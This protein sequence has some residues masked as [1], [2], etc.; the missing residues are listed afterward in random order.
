M[1]GVS[2]ERTI[3][4]GPNAVTT[5][6][7]NLETS[8]FSDSEAE[9]RKY[10]NDNVVQVCKETEYIHIPDSAH[11]VE[12][13]SDK[14][15]QDKSSASE[16]IITEKSAFGA[17]M[18]N[19]K[20]SALSVQEVFS[21][22]SF[23]MPQI[24]KND[25]L[26]L[27]NVSLGD[28]PAGCV[29]SRTFVN[30]VTEA[31]LKEAMGNI[32]D[33]Y[34][35]LYVHFVLQG[36]LHLLT[37]ASNKAAEILRDYRVRVEPTHRTPVVVVEENAHIEN[38]YGEED[39]DN[40]E[41]EDF[42]VPSFSCSDTVTSSTYPPVQADLS[43]GTQLSA[44]LKDF[45][46]FITP[47]TLSC[48][49]DKTWVDENVTDVLICIVAVMSE[50]QDVVISGK[51]VGTL[52]DVEQGIGLLT[53]IMSSR[54][55]LVETILPRLIIDS[56]RNSSQNVPLPNDIYSANTAIHSCIHGRG[57]H[58]LATFNCEDLYLSIL[59]CVPIAGD[60]QND[61]MAMPSQRKNRK[62]HVQLGTDALAP[63]LVHVNNRV[64][65]DGWRAY[66]DAV[67]IC[68]P[69]IASHAAKAV[70]VLS[71]YKQHQKTLRAHI[72]KQQQNGVSV[73]EDSNV[74]MK[75]IKQAS[76]RKAVLTEDS[77][78]ELR[79]NVA[80]IVSIVSRYVRHGPAQTVA[81][82][83]LKYGVW[84]D[85]VRLFVLV[86]EIRDEDARTSTKVPTQ[87]E[88]HIL[89]DRDLTDLVAL[90]TVGC[91][92]H[93]ELYTYTLRVAEA[94]TL[95]I[96]D[97]S[98]VKCNHPDLYMI[99]L[100]MYGEKRAPQAVYTFVHA[101]HV[102]LLNSLNN[103]SMHVYCEE[104]AVFFKDISALLSM[105]SMFRLYHKGD[106]IKMQTKTIYSNAKSEST[107][108]ST[109]DAEQVRVWESM[110]PVFEDI[111]IYME[112]LLKAV[113]GVE[114]FRSEFGLPTKVAAAPL[115]SDK[116]PVADEKKTEG[117]TC[118]HSRGRTHTIA[119]V[120]DLADMFRSAST[121]DGNTSASGVSELLGEGKNVTTITK[122]D[123]LSE[124]ESELQEKV[125]ALHD[126]CWRML[127][128]VHL[129]LKKH[130]TPGAS[131]NKSD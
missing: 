106:V 115:V 107:S 130:F 122:A 40:Y 51:G 131:T 111:Y 116:G 6:S 100:C 120:D 69:I 48:V 46:G 61:E 121:S 92:R 45:Y 93:V 39:D 3:N 31:A 58:C 19:V 109:A 97:L 36:L 16:T 13:Y 8:S 85:L 91:C 34:E 112:S 18:V 59:E 73:E 126:N 57:K 108:R 125:G 37:H 30:N 124:P 12:R 22:L 76:S 82:E 27:L 5:G 123:K 54:P 86:G 55:I 96:G 127:W 113:K 117:S 87:T 105:L 62:A 23:D 10:M 7:G 47:T 75:L 88:D 68:L 44:K 53:A 102:P 104:A 25:A 77:L 14:N 65:Y 2:S 29:L 1:M 70:S 52:L 56:N 60:D 32:G 33:V 43:T 11:E 94:K 15:T 80:S 72:L 95:L 83:L 78:S 42:D 119:S 63:S 110:L 35:K 89:Q 67:S 17:G 98:A 103:L 26:V 41:F 20:E 9:F 28:L 81:G 79:R 49:S 21:K 71:E 118:E 101:L 50:Y 24:T 128:R 129:I 38:T 74:N 64:S 99:W 66:A 4:G 84:R 114:Q 90:L